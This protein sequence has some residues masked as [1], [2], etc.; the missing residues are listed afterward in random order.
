ML[1]RRG[2]KLTEIDSVI[3]LERLRSGPGKGLETDPA[4]FLSLTYPT[5]E[6][7]ATLK[8]LARRFGGSTAE[9]AGTGLVL[10]EAHKGLGKSHVL[11]LVHHLFTNSRAA[12]PWLDRLGETLDL[13]ADA[14]VVTT[15]FT[16]ERLPFDSLWSYIGK[17]LGVD[18]PGAERPDLAEFRA[19]LGER[20]LVLIFDELERGILCIADEA[21]RQKNLAFLQMISEEANRSPQV[22]LFATVYD[23][24]REPGATLKRIPRVQLRFRS[25]EDRAGIVRHRLF[26]DADSYD[27]E[28]AE[29]VVRSW[30]NAWARLEVP[31]DDAYLERMR[32]SFPF[33]PEVIDLVFSEISA[34][35]SVQGTRGALGL[36]GA[37]LQASPP[38]TPLVT[39]AH[40]RVSDSACADRLQD[41]DPSGVLIRHAQAQCRDL[42]GAP[43]VEA[44]A[45]AVLL[46]SLARAPLNREEV[47][48][49]VVTP[50]V[51][52]NEFES[53][54]RQ[55]EEFG[56]HFFH[57]E[58]RYSFDTEENE[59][60]KVNSAAI[61]RSEAEATD[62]IRRIWLGEVFRHPARS[63]VAADIDS[64]K[65]RLQDLPRSG[66]RFVLAHRALSAEERHRLYF[67]EE[68]RNQILLFEPHLRGARLLAD[69]DLQVYARRALAA[70]ELAETAASA[71][72]R[73][74]YERIAERERGRIRETIRQAGLV[75]VRVEQ[76]G[77]TATDCRFEI[78]PMPGAAA[79]E[80][81]LRALRETTFPQALL[82]EH[83][84]EHLEDLW[85][86]RVGEIDRRYRITL[87]FPVPLSDT[88]I[89]DAVRR[90]VE[91][92]DRLAGL[93]HP[94]GNFCGESVE[95]DG[96]DLADA[97][98]TRPWTAA[99][100]VGEPFGAANA[101]QSGKPAGDVAEPD[102]VPPP[103]RRVE[104]R[105]SYCRDL[106]A[107]R[108]EVAQQLDRH[109]ALEVAEMTFEIVARA[110]GARVAEMPAGLR[111]RADGVGELEVQVT[112]RYDS[113]CPKAEAENRCETLP[114]LPNAEYHVR[115]T[116]VVDEMEAESA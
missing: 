6:V 31:R 29:A 57:R 79:H 82:V 7:R 102:A 11:V 67:G 89:S 48:R 92:R 78:E 32:A 20:F 91:S 73:I 41:L 23:G 21:Q 30:T 18:W 22:T 13:P 93:Q 110:E 86:Q 62:E 65:Q 99:P 104:V 83:L 9:L 72:R 108:Q 90:L 45:S 49:H 4:R 50:G 5:T 76:W 71:D 75:Y 77:E 42:A 105:T 115:L 80:D 111:G 46:G 43:W 106:G 70:R 40:A 34:M 100:R 44:I 109:G 63:V 103:G 54:L 74:K 116:A 85:D 60:A 19:A 10:A 3:D 58:G 113:P 61:R 114:R 15:K 98:L 25:P 28:A 37:M 53:T 33:L 38:D 36:V 47:I 16:D 56:G 88:A 95:L 27:R 55:L 112:L 51:D 24:D 101:A 87:G 14:V 94:R 17:P 97:T 96:G 64:A 2:Q 1:K 26:E 39:A 68:N 59:N 12:K 107:L 69:A 81:V 52:P 8:A 66:L 35:A 84:Q